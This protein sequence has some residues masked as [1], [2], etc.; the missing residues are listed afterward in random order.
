[1]AN[2]FVTHATPELVYDVSLRMRERDLEEILAVCWES[3]REE[4]AH[5]L[6]KRYGNMPMCVCF[7]QD[8]QPIC[9]MSAIAIHPGVWSMG[10]W[11][12][13]DFPKIG[14]FI[15]RWALQHFFPALQKAGLHRL[16]CKSIIGY[17]EVHEWLRYLGFHEGNAEKMYGK[18]GED[19]I[20][21]YWH[22]GAPIG[23]RLGNTR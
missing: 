2:N 8:D 4:L 19:F 10:L 13:D 11:A 3:N 21:F 9:I 18:G 12:T 6:A 5:G 16:E 20:T 22:E 7:G 23:K 1:M 17:S 15:T 14:R